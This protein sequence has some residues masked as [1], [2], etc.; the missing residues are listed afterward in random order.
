[1]R[2]RGAWLPSSLF[3]HCCCCCCC[4]SSGGASPE[5]ARSAA[6]ACAPVPAGGVPSRALP[7]ECSAGGAGGVCA[8]AMAG[9]MG[10]CSSGGFPC[11]RHATSASSSAPV[12][13]SSPALAFWDD[14]GV[15]SGSST[16]VLLHG[17]NKPREAM[18]P[19]CKLTSG[20]GTTLRKGGT[21]L[22]K[23]GTTLRKDGT[24]LR[25]NGCL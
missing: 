13:G 19:M 23:G 22:R 12:K 15:P 20:I 6:A 2:L 21:T 18:R 9:D 11:A 7:R 25:K 3:C 8:P 4:S 1:M 16:C 24:T 10:S 5:L 17:C 14:R